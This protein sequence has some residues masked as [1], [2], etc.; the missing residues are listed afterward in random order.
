[1]SDA[2]RS[3]ETTYIINASIEDS[4]IEA[5]IARIA[6]VIE[7]NGG[8][9]TATNRWGRK[10]MAYAIEKKN[11]GFY[12]NVE[13]EGPARMI[14]QLERVY[15]L[16]ENIIRFLTILLDKYA[17]EA[18]TKKEAETTAALSP[19]GDTPPTEKTA[20]SATT[21]KSGNTEKTA[22]PEETGKP[23]EPDQKKAEPRA[24]LFTGDEK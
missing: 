22:I 9:I 7:R 18:R 3:Y 8:T 19:S 5:T 13:F 15:Q 1:M 20:G 2:R 6:E 16:D 17:L 24:P 10:R 12:I 14:A 4:Q 21:E 23:S 11:N